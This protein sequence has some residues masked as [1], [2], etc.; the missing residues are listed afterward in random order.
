MR[1][2]RTMLCSVQFE[3]GASARA[4]RARS[5]L[6]QLETRLELA[7]LVPR[8]GLDSTR[9]APAAGIVANVD[10]RP[11]QYVTIGQAMCSLVESGSLYIEANLKETELTHI[12]VGNEATVTVD[13]YPGRVWHARVT[14][15]DATSVTLSHRDGS[16]RLPLTDLPPEIRKRF[17]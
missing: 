2:T 6:V 7:P 4:R 17:P 9:L 3:T 15:I 10:P 14:S 16:S 13:T 5:P 12:A 8:V 1:D 11:G